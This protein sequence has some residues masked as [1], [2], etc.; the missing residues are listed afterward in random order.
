MIFK[1]NLFISDDG[2]L[3]AGWRLLLQ[4]VLAVLFLIPFQYAASLAGGRNLQILAG[5]SA[6]ILSV[7][8]AGLLFD[9]RP[10]R[11]FGLGGGMPWWKEFAAGFLMAFGVM[12][13]IVLFLYLKGWIVFTGYGWNRLSDSHYLVHLGTYILVM[14]MVGF[15]EELWTRGYQIKNLMEGLLFRNRRILAAVLAVGISS[16]FFGLLHY[17]NPNA[18]AFGVV[19]IILAGIMLAFPFVVTGRLGMSVG[20]HFSWNLIQGGLYGLPVSGLRF[21][22]AVFQFELAGPEIWTGGSF[23]PEGGLVGLAGVVLIIGLTV[24]WLRS[25]RPKGLDPSLFQSP[26]GTD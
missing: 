17:G 19:V 18:T 26:D 15:Y 8:T 14:A 12:S 6:V 4:A 13:V 2:R 22:H 10:L 25:C 23:G 5:G 3:R 16:V 11:A 7:W 20:I 21:R 24:L 1:A 9:K